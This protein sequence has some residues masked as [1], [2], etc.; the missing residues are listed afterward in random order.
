MERKSLKVKVE[1]EI[2]KWLIDSSGWGIEEISKKLKVKDFTFKKWLTGESLPTLNQIEKISNYLKRPL[3]AFFLSKPPLEKPMPRDYRMLPNRS[4]IFEKK[5]L[6]A[7]RR[8]RR[9]QSISKELMINLG[10]DTKP[11][12]SLVQLSE[13]PESVA[14]EHREL[15]GV[16]VID[17]INWSDSREAFDNWRRLVAERNLMVFQISMPIEDVRGF[18][19]VEENPLVIVI[20][21]SDS[22]EAR[23]FTL[24]HEYGHILLNKSGICILE[25]HSIKE[26]V[27]IS[28]ERW[29]NEFASAFLLPKKE[30]IEYFS[31]IDKNAILKP[32]TI[33][34]FSKKYK[35]S[36]SM[37]FLNML[38]LKIIDETVYRKV[39]SDIKVRKKKAQFGIA[40]DK[41]CVQERGEKFVSMVY[42]NVSNGFIT[43]NDAL[44]Y[45]SLKSKYYSE[46]QSKLSK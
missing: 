14:N 19:L 24:F 5:T 8:A 20:N 37:I 13:D 46:L 35:V 36:K 38:K 45:L 23:I 33:N 9:L 41:K 34:M 28:V 30:I 26:S 25:H 21:S 18:S 15:F 42:S 16:K 6:L 29:C 39:M 1:P 4:G 31:N 43:N 22:L 2:L 44:D 27:E 17:Q 10:I 32:R 11:K 12:F 3:A 40:P 7:L